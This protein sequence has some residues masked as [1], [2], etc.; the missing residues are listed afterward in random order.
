[1]SP[2][3][4]R[5]D[6][7]HATRWGE[8]LFFQPF[9]SRIQGMLS[10]YHH[11]AKT[12]SF[13]IPYHRE[14]IYTRRSALLFLLVNNGFISDCFGQPILYKTTRNIHQYVWPLTSSTYSEALCAAVA[15]SP[16][17]VTTCRSDLLMQSPQAKIPFV[18]VF[19]S[20]SAII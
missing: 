10:L 9:S 20:Q 12:G 1:M 7:S 4:N 8:I 14:C 16:Q 13:Q 11:P 15:P 18:D 6:R 17:A 19:I 3:P 2:L 5:P